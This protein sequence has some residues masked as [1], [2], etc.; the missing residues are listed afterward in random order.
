[1]QTLDSAALFVLYLDFFYL[2]ENPR[3]M[4]FYWTVTLSQR[5]FNPIAFF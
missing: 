4:T 1:M 5:N 2:V 3:K